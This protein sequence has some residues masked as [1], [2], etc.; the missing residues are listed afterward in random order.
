MSSL[1]AGARSELSAR[2]QE[3]RALCGEMDALGAE[4]RHVAAD[5]RYLLDEVPPAH[6][7]SASNLIHYLVLRHHDL[8]ALQPR[9]SALGLS[10]L[11]RS[12]AQVLASV[13]AVRVALHALDGYEGE[14]AQSAADTSGGPELLATH[15]QALLGPAPAKR[16]VRIMVTA[17]S[18][19]AHDY[20]LVYELVRAGMD[21]LRINC[22]HDDAPACPA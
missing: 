5:D 11:G 14:P 13:E 17:S 7:A 6:Q 4:I 3:I 18:E 20:T 16:R 12:E 2:A 10:S 21:C 15:T 1:P 22:A 8:R 19:A 9:L